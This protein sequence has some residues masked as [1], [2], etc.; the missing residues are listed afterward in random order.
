MTP[1]ST[2]TGWIDRWSDV[3]DD[4]S[5]AQVDV[6]AASTFLVS[7]VLLWLLSEVL[8]PFV[9]GIALAYVQAPLADRL[10]RLG[11]NR[12]LAALLIVTV[13]VLAL[14]AVALLVVPILVQQALALIANLPGHVTRVRELIADPNRPWLELD[15]RR[16]SEQDGLRARPPR[17][18]RGWPRSPIRCGPAERRWS[19][20]PRC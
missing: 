3:A 5:A 7:G 18:R 9:A 12:T 11:L 6:L 4:R 20:S 13:V 16:R 15:R 10:E 17:R 1:S 14:L 19:R 2:G 8:L